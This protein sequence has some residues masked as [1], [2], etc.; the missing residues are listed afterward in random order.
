MYSRKEVW[1]GG[2]CLGS[3]SC[4]LLIFTPGHYPEESTI[5][6][7]NPLKELTPVVWYKKIHKKSFSSSSPP[8]PLG[9][10][11]WFSTLLLKSQGDL[12]LHP[13]KISTITY[14]SSVLRLLYSNSTHLIPPKQRL[15]KLTQAAKAPM[16]VKT[17]PTS[18]HCPQLIAI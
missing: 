8:T 11:C 15:Y 5:L 2:V 14:S 3:L 13:W 6:G 10:T 16:I 18:P 17:M 4:F 7:E 9:F 1:V 12:R